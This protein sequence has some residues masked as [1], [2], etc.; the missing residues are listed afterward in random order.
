MTETYEM[1]IIQVHLYCKLVY[2]NNETF[3]KMIDKRRSTSL[4]KL[5]TGESEAVFLGG[6]LGGV[7]PGS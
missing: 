5:H 7:P 4:E 2:I 1:M 6:L 3:K